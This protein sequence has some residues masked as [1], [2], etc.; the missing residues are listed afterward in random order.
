MNKSEDIKK[1]RISPGMAALAGWYV[2]GDLTRGL[3]QPTAAQ[4]REFERL[5]FS[6]RVG[7]SCLAYQFIF[8]LLV[9]LN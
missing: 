2:S 5:A 6:K 3:G 4:Q 8:R 7:I 9:F 1:Q